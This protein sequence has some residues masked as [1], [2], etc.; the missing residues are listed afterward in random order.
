M[1][2]QI[3]LPLN[4]N[5]DNYA[6][7]SALGAW[8][9]TPTYAA[10]TLFG[11]QCLTTGNITGT[12]NSALWNKIRDTGEYSIC[13]WLRKA[14]NSKSC[15]VFRLGGDNKATRGFW[16]GEDGGS[17]TQFHFA[18]SSTGI[19]IPTNG[20]NLVDGYWHHIVFTVK[21]KVWSF[22]AD[23]KY[24]SSI[25]EASDILPLA[26]NILGLYSDWQ[27]QDFRLYDHQLT[28]AEVKEIS[29]GLVGHYKLTNFDS[30][31]EF[32]CSGYRYNGVHKGSGGY[33]TE[34]PRYNT[35]LTCG[36]SHWVEIHNFAKPQQASTWCA[37]VKFDGKVPSPGINIL[38]STEA[39]GFEIY[40]LNN[41]GYPGAEIYVNGA[42]R[43]AEATNILTAGWHF[44]VGTWDGLKTCL[45]VDGVLIKTSPALTTKTAA[46]Y[47]ATAPFCIGTQ[48][49]AT[50]G[51]GNWANMPISDVRLYC[52]A[53]SADDIKELYQTSAA[54]DK[55]G[56]LMAYEFI[57]D[58][59]AT[60]L[61]V[62]KNGIAAGRN[63]TTYKVLPDN[64]HWLLLNYLDVGSKAECFASNDE[65][66]WCTNKS[67][68]Y[69]I[70]KLADLFKNSSGVYEFMLEYPEFSTTTRNR[71][72]QTSAPSA[73]TGTGYTA[74]ETAWSNYKG[75]I[76]L[77]TGA[78]AAYWCNPSGNWFAPV[79][80]KTLWN[81]GIP[82]ANGSAAKVSCFWVRVDTLSEDKL[83][84]FSDLL[85]AQDIKEW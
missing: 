65:V 72:T 50:Y 5:L 70:M 61:Q 35:S 30:T 44:L 29:R 14:G 21:N 11:N 84:L 60:K 27:K 53:L 46:T 79:G 77:G 51:N 59:A 16:V 15:F 43:A 81:N 69:S 17:A 4:G 38:S 45:Y 24:L 12:L 56:N 64:S 19:N 8:S 10:S 67:N 75:E 26:P 52:T 7:P 48:A 9:G 28:A 73:A 31:T 80:Q 2:L 37:W 22:Y 47:H 40:F 18:Y 76:H 6:N 41:S 63:F 33:Q 39:G 23:G 13:V 62:S 34:S 57:E 1:S 71:W 58:E 66:E 49:Q 42:Y 55:S 54:I 78:A 32:D 3:W 82:A 74:I 68:R 36:S 83:K 85:I 20:V 25:T